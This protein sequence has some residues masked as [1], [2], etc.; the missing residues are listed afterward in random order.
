M[1]CSAPPWIA[2]RYDPRNFPTFHHSC[3]TIHFMNYMHFS[4]A[5]FTL[6]YAFPDNRISKLLVSYGD[7]RLHA[8][9]AFLTD[10]IQTKTV[11]VKI[12]VEPKFQRGGLH[13][14]KQV[15]NICCINAQEEMSNPW[16]NGR[17]FESNEGQHLLLWNIVPRISHFD[18]YFGKAYNDITLRFT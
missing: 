17:E 15:E 5:S 10:A 11:T 2:F 7:P 16:Q 14:W 1:N 8:L 3:Y 9:T 12:F 6:P 4:I 13:D 18:W